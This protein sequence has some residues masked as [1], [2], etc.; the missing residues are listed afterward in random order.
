MTDMPG[1]VPLAGDWRPGGLLARPTRVLVTGVAGFIGAHVAAALGALGHEVVGVDDVNGYYDVALK[2]QRLA[3]LPNGV[4]V[5]EISVADLAFVA[6]AGEAR[7][8][9]VIHLAA[10]AGVRYSIEN[11]RAYVEANVMGQIGALEAARAAGAA[12]LVYASSSS[13]YGLERDMPFHTAMRADDPASVYAATKRSGELLTQAF[14]RLHAVPATGL[15]FFTVYGPWGRPDMA[16]MLF[17]DAILSGHPIRLFNGGDMRR[18]FTFI[19]DIVEGVLR[20]ADAAPEG[21]PPH[22]L[23]NIG[24]GAPVDLMDFV[25]TLEAALGREALLERLPMQPGDVP[26]T[27]ADTEALT[28]DTGF[29]PRTT[30]D[31]GIA[32]FADWYRPWREVQVQAASA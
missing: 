14:A 4:P 29:S 9:V 7:P 5:H 2:R 22:R 23:Y 13:V 25:R 32:A 27:W 16:P 21:D 26:A 17:A 11:P 1:L 6:L 28:A 18:D 24:R 19:A 30:L 15:R 10:Q 8:T 20:A 31:D 12:H 3:R